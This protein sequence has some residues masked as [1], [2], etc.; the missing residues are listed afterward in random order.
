MLRGLQDTTQ[1]AKDLEE[2]KSGS[3]QTENDAPIIS[4]E[5]GTVKNV[6]KSCIGYIAN[7]TIPIISIATP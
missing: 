2:N 5:K 4:V 3:E 7:I 6:M 1:A